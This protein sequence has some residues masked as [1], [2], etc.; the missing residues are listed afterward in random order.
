MWKKFLIVFTM[1]IVGYFANG[2]YGSIPQASAERVYAT[3]YN[4]V[5]Y[6][7][8]T[9]E[10]SGTRSG[11]TYVGVYMTD[12]RYYTWCFDSYREWKYS[13]WPGGMG[14]ARQSTGWKLVKDS[15]VANDILYVAL[16]EKKKK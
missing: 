14:N 11:M 2:V 10:L 3:T 13:Y 6:Y 9:D 8:E 16:I 4:G 5:D 15:K 7:I 1:A 12:G